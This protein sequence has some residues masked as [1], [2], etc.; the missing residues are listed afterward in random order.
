LKREEGIGRGREMLG[1]KT[2]ATVGR[3]ANL[4]N[5]QHTIGRGGE[6]KE[7]GVRKRG[8][9]NPKELL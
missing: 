5:E 4:S 1:S 3:G 2:G 6:G 9:P 7:R 8:S